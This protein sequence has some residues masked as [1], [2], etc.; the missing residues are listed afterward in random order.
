MVALLPSLALLLATLGIM[1]DRCPPTSPVSPSSAPRS[2]TARTAFSHCSRPRAVSGDSAPTASHHTFAN[3]LIAV[4]DRRFWHHPGVDPLALA[5]ATAQ[6]VRRGRVVSGGSTL[7]MQTA[8]LLEPRPRTVHA[9]LIEMARALQLE[10]RYGRDG[11]LRIW[12]TLAPFGGNLEGIRAGS[13]AWFGVP[14]EALEPAEAALL[15][16]IPRRPERL[17]PDRHPI[18][19]QVVRDRVLAIGV[20]SDLFADGSVPVPTTRVSLPR[21]APQLA[22][23]LPRSPQVH[24]TLDLPLQTA[25]ERLGEERLQTLPPHASIA[26]LV[27]D[28][29]A[30]AIRRCIRGH[31]ATRSAPALSTSARRFARPGQR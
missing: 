27:A 26:I 31:G 11:V 23:S 16:A 1:L 28:A 2:T 22:A 25:L 18:A 17:R 15:V 29:P 30:R 8:R 3:L 13:L 12:L 6:L 21:H 24:T 4:E 9:K 7:A 14:P 5:R 10:A 20:R 19:A